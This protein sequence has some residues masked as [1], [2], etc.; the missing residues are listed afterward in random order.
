MGRKVAV[1]AVVACAVV[2]S[3]VLVGGQVGSGGFLWWGN[4][5]PIYIYGN[6]DF[7]VKNG[8]MSGSGTAADPYIIE[9]W[10][11][12]SP[13]ADY[14]IYIDH[15]TAHF[16]VRDCVIESTRRA[17]IYLNTV[18]NGRIE[19]T[20]VG[21]SDTAVYLLDSSR[22]VFTMNVIAQSKYGV[23]MAAYSRENVIYNN[24][25]YDNGLNGHDPERRNR[26]YDSCVGNYWSDYDGLDS[27]GDGIGDVPYYALMDEFPLM[28]PSVDWTRVAPAGLSYSGNQVSPEGAL[29]VTSQTPISLV[30]QD[31][32]SGLETIMYAI[33]RSEWAEYTGP[34][35]LTGDDGPRT[36]RYY[37][38]DQL[39]NAEQ[40]STVRFVLDNHPPVTEIT[41]G[42]PKYQDDRALWVTSASEFTLE[43]VQESTYGRATT[44]FQIDS[45]GWMMYNGPFRISGPDGPYTIAYY[46]RN[47]SG[48]TEE[49][50]TLVVIKDD[51]PPSTRGSQSSQSSSGGIGVQVGPP[52][53]EPEPTP[54]PEPEMETPVV[55]EP[56]PEPE[57]EP[58][59]ETPVV[60]EPEPEPEP[61]PVV[62]TPAEPEPEPEVVETPETEEETAPE[63][64]VVEPETEPVQTPSDESV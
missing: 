13:K 60:V 37:G 9:G 19:H 50:Q 56:E 16:V 52:T 27:D 43:R 57:P 61:E 39:G 47:A 15:T 32:G 49:I 41:V 42:D 35:Y 31:P 24:S 18:K 51:A 11:I 8:V 21:L 5:E 63:M 62:E 58:V 7:T 36:L 2:L 53:V 14:G 10:R 22:N 44:Y 28:T 6:D 34:I 30:S 1:C 20:Q 64:P 40:E 59:V 54:E 48:V 23:V 46:S 45:R 12:D 25:F 38:I 17:G 33:D 55:V 3:V 4:H 26:W 29:V